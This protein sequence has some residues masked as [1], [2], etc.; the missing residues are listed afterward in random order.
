MAAELGH[1]CAG[2]PRVAGAAAGDRVLRARALQDL[3]E[4]RPRG[5]ILP[6]AV[7]YEV[8][9]ALG[10]AL[11]VG[12]LLRDAE[13]QGVHT[14]VRGAEG[15]PARGG[16]GKDRAEAEDVA[17]GRD[18]VAAHLLGRHEAGRTDERAGTGESAVGHRLQG[19]GD[20][21]VDDAGAV[22]GDQDVGRLEVA[23]DDP[24]GVD[25]LERVRQTGAQRA[26]GALRQRAVV[27]PDDLLEAGPRDVPG[28][29]PRHGRLGVRV[30][31]GRRPV[32][33]D[34]A[35]GLDLLPEPLAELLQRGQFL[36]HQLHGDGAPAVRAGQI[37]VAHAARTQPPQEPIDPDVLWVPVPQTPHAAPPSPERE[38]QNVS[39]RARIVRGGPAASR[40]L[41]TV[42]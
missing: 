41:S 6:Q 26:Y 34:P 37:D 5:G 4:T 23:V 7:A 11:Q 38:Q 42:P 31:Y 27:V 21:E 24:G 36:A 30:Q 12:F 40:R 3:G 32:P 18:T 10:H 20:A 9:D 15:Q 14:A 19:A 13:H 2:Q 17:R 28:G 8:G 29:H 1:Q 25:V 22:D 39:N 16:V 35:R 33:A